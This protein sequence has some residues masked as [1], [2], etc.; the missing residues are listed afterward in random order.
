[1]AVKKTSQI[2]LYEFRDFD[3][4]RF[5]SLYLEEIA[6]RKDIISVNMFTGEAHYVDIKEHSGVKKRDKIIA[7]CQYLQDTIIR[8]ANA[9]KDDKSFSLSSKILT[10]VIGEEYKSMLNVLIRMGYIEL[11]NGNGGADKHFY[12]EIGA[13]SML[14][15]LKDAPIHCWYGHNAA[16]RK[17]KEKAAEKIDE[18]KQGCITPVIDRLYG[19]SFRKQ[20]LTSLN[21]FHVDDVEGLKEYIADNGYDKEESPYYIYYKDIQDKM[22]KGKEIYSVDSNG[23]IYHVL[24]NLTKELKEYINIDFSLDCKNSH[25][26]LFNFFIFHHHS[27]PV[28]SSFN[29]CNFLYNNNYIK[30][31]Y[32]KIQESLSLTIYHN[33]SE[34][35]RKELIKNNIEINQV[36]KLSDDELE[37]I[38]LT[39]IGRLWDDVN[40]R[41]PEFSRKEI[42]AKFFGEVLYSKTSFVKNKPFAQE[43]VQ[44]FPSVYKLICD[45]KKPSKHEEISAYLKEHNLAVKKEHAALSIAM[46]NLEAQIFTSALK[47]MYSKRWKAVNIHDCIVVP[48]TGLKNHPTMESV[49]EILKDVF[50]GYGLCPTFD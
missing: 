11:G 4:E 25:P 21:Y 7:K 42:K 2:Q 24:C 46:M 32:I 9:K 49:R 6:P 44:M 26:L 19:Q 43:F 13:Y 20:Y 14:Y 31:S 35:L 3:M 41:H 50:R 37:Y 39:S 38:Y 22:S 29:I 45:W 33:V 1:M 40:M 12:Y 27:I 48:N 47:R 10:K 34:I 18:Y 23:R 30:K 36:A 8:R 15:K 17:Y 28:V 5:I 16:V